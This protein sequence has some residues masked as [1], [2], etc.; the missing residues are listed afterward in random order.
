MGALHGLNPTTGWMWAAAWGVQ[1]RDRSQV[2]RALLPIAAGHAASVVL[3][4]GV[5]AAGLS[6]GSLLLQSVAGGLLVI[7]TVVHVSRRRNGRCAKT[8]SAYAGHA[9]LALWSFMMATAHGAGLMLVPALTPLC[10][11]EGPVRAITAS[12]SWTLAIAAVAVHMGAM[13]LVTGAMAS[14]ACRGMTRLL[15]SAR[16]AFVCYARP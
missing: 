14:G 12:G 9:G 15:K 6:R 4:A 11:G 8:A 5:V 13:L 7:V 3:V 10:M 1:S 16:H 2:M